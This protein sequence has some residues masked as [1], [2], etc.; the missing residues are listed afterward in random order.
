MSKPVILTSEEF[1]RVYEQG[2]E[3][4]YALFLTLISPLISRIEELERRLG[5]SSTNSSKPPSSDGLAKPAP[6]PKSLRE[7]TGKKPGGQEGHKGT[8]LTPKD[9]PDFIEVHEPHQCNCGCN[10]EETEGTVIRKIQVADLPEIALQY[11]EHQVIEK[12]C[13]CCHQ[14]SHGELPQGIEDT[15]V[16]YGQRV[17][18]LLTYLS[19]GQYLSYER[20]VELCEA[21]FGFTPSEGT[22]YTAMQNCSE[23]L[24][25][26]EEEVKEELKKMEVLNCDETG[27]RMEGKTAW[28]HVASTEKLTHYHVDEKRGKT[29]MDHIGI[30]DGFKGTVIH[31]C[32]SSYFQ[33]DGLSHGL[34]NAHILRELKNVSEEMCQAWAC[35]MSELLR[36]G[37][38]EKAEKGIPD[39]TGYEEYEKAYMEILTRGR[40]QQPPPQPK[41]EGQRGRRKKSTSE[42]LLERMERYRDYILAFLKKDEVPFTNNQAER[43]IRMVKVKMKVSGSFRTK[44]GARIFARIRSAISTFQKQGKR[45]F[46]ELCGVFRGIPS[47]LS[48]PE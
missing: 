14:K 43:D 10:L 36:R 42:N 44:E 32:L 19:V 23:G 9:V 7:K 17:L 13:P 12:E 40:E 39:A 4:T 31:D 34:C 18:A 26:F 35:E 20:I 37:C 15:T 1:H 16:Q 38:K 47:R 33:Y 46:D 24:E 8:T 22:I 21:L 5:L 30:L 27:I 28:F 3:A 6:K 41:P 48:S 29:A 45:I 2:E 11:T 25:D